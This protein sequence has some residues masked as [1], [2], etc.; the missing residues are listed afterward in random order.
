MAYVPSHQTL[1]NHPKLKRLSRVLGTSDVTSIGHLQCFW[2]W[3][4]DYAPGGSL[5]GHDALDIAIG[6]EWEGNETEFLDA[7]IDCGFIDREGDSLA[8]H[9]W[10]DYGGYYQNKLIK[11][12]ERKREERRA[13]RDVQATSDDSPT[14]VLEMSNRRP[15]EIQ[16]MAPQEEEKRK[17][18]SNVN[19]PTPQ[20]EKY[21]AE[22]SEFW[23][24]YPRKKNKDEAWRAWKARRDRPALAVLIGSIAEHQRSVDWTKDGG[25]YIPNPATWIRAGGWKDE[26]LTPLANVN[27]QG[28]P[29]PGY[30]TM[31]DWYVSA[32]YRQQRHEVAMRSIV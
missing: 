10:D 18:K 19:P 14:D 15:P 27:G 31:H 5:N 12:A 30:A 32:E 7:L 8:I 4:L 6:A 28:K 9:D 21:S 3:A 24:A 29:P 17:E 13:K 26:E 20:G 2:W 11:D 16:W 22:F 23:A 1:R 25:A